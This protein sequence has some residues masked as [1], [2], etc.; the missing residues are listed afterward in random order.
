MSRSCFRSCFQVDIDPI[1]KIFKIS[2]HHFW[3]PV[4]SK[5]DKI[6]FRTFEICEHIVFC[7]WKTFQTVVLICLSILAS[8]KINIIGLG[9]SGHVPK[10]RNQR[11]EGFCLSHKQIKKH[12]TKSQ[13]NNSPELPNLL[14]K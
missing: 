6:D 1:S 2:F 7:F 4:F 9:G 3:A 13:Q 10:S 14:F 12:Y 11:N 5:I 8:P